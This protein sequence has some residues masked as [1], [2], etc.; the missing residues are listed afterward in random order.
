MPYHGLKPTYDH[1]NLSYALATNTPGPNSYPLVYL[2]DCAVVPT[3][4][5]ATVL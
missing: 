5:L 2:R 1:A 3:S 4:S